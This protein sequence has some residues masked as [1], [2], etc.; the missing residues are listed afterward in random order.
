MKILLLLMAMLVGAI[1]IIKYS[2]WYVSVG[3][4]V[5]VVLGGK[6]ILKRLITRLFTAPFK[7]KGRALQGAELKV[8]SIEPAN[9]PE[10]KE[11]EDTDGTKDDG[12]DG[13][14]DE[15][16]KVEREERRED[17]KKRRWFSLDVT[18]TPTPKEED[19][20][21]FR[22][23]EPGELLLVHADKNVGELD[24]DDDLVGEGLCLIHDLKYQENG[25]FVDDDGIKFEGEQRLKLLIGA[26]PEA[27]RLK[28][29]YYFEAFGE[30]TLPKG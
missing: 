11:E 4:A 13:D 15:D 9:M 24:Q 2:P 7:M 30:V 10:V 28:F 16:E 17:Y 27:E 14:E 26:Q 12:E 3:L 23:W 22:H 21:G 19:T 20:C 1:L 18:I 25:S 8:N 5:L 6:F 29:Q